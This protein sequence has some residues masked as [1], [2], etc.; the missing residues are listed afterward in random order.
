M[1]AM[2]LTVEHWGQTTQ[3]HDISLFTLKN[4]VLNVQITNLGAALVTVEAPDRDGVRANVNLR[5]ATGETYI[6]NPSSFGAICGRYANRIGKAKFSLDG[7]EYTLVANNG[8]NHLHGGA[9]GFNR[10]LW[11]AEPQ[12]DHITFR[13]VSPAGDEGYPGQLSVDVTYRLEKN[14]LT[15]DYVATTD[16]P[17][18]LNLTNH[19]YWNLGGV[20]SGVIDDHILQ[21]NSAQYL[22]A[23]ENVLVTGEIASVENTPFDFRTPQTIGSRIDQI[24]IGGYDHCFVVGGEAGTLRKAARVV[25]PASG[26]IMEVETTEPGVQLYTANHF[27][28]GSGCAGAP[29]HGAFCLE[30]QHYPD[31]PN[32]PAFP[33]TV[34]RPGQQYTQSTVH[35]FLAE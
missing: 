12:A 13:I 16:A 29:K 4:D 32:Q 23:D 30:C 24:D 15:I 10:Y 3:G 28:G 17:T 31:S 5:H 14:E 27:N 11:S 8:P 7:K 9:V 1:K 25:H 34:L 21:L 20:A 2:S 35:R 22:I 19:A 33:S 6:Q 18:V 26:R